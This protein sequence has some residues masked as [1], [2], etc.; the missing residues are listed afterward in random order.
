MIVICIAMATGYSM[1]NETLTIHGTAIAKME[2][3]EIVVPPVGTDENGVDRFSA[4]TSVENLFG[5]ELL[6]VTSEECVGNSITTTMEVVSR[7]ALLPRTLEISLQI[8]NG[9]KYTFTNGTVE[10]I[11]SSDSG[12]A[13]TPNSQTLNPVTV[14]P[15]S[16][17]TVDIRGTVNVG[18]IETGTF[19]Q[20]RIS[21]ESEDGN[22]KEFYYTLKLEP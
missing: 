13:F 11:D 4:T 10:L 17:T 14:E 8:Q 9:S 6:R 21:F 20:Y 2:E 1:F 22:I 18:R 19:Y 12:N 5:M 15:G 3:E 16:T 7:F